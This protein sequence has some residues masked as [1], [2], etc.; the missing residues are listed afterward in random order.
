MTHHWDE[1]SKSL[2][3]ESLPRRES[4][5]RLGFL[6][7][8]AVL[9]PLG[10]GTAWGRGSDPCTNFCK[11]CPSSQRSGCLAVCQACNS[12]TKR[13]AGSCGNYTCCGA[14]Q[15]SC[16]RY[17][18]DLS[19]DWY[20]CGACG[21]GCYVA[22]AYESSACIDGQCEY[23]CVEGAGR[24]DGICTGLEYDPNNC[25][26]CGVVCPSSA[27]YCNQGECS[28]C[29]PGLTFCTDQYSGSVY[30]ADLMWDSQ[31]CGACGNVCNL[32]FGESCWEGLCTHF[33][34]GWGTVDPWF[35]P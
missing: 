27:P 16:R 8:G 10:V 15:T 24:C 18:A 26:A 14:G 1:F 34:E 19:N 6:F 22:N 5:R 32:S 28:V 4:L 17:C 21:H 30:C 7:A 2:A 25:G 9:S 23:W 31:N 20:N 13:L 12:D 11:H 3:E 33:P 29:E 35:I